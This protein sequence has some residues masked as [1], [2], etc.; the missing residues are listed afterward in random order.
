MLPH[1]LSCFLIPFMHFSCSK[2][3]FFLI[4]NPRLMVLE[5]ANTIILVWYELFNDCLLI[6][7]VALS[8]YPSIIRWLCPSHSF[9]WKPYTLIKIS[10][11]H[12]NNLMQVSLYQILSIFPFPLFAILLLSALL[13][14]MF[15]LIP[16]Q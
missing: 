4:N 7:L 15:Q 6:L 9:I 3:Y 13:L 5:K 12:D 16:L 2:L 11:Q 10:D 8:K 14:F 1:F